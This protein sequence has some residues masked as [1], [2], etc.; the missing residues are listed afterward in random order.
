MTDRLYRADQVRQV[1]PQ[2]WVHHRELERKTL[3]QPSH[4]SSVRILKTVVA[5]P[6]SSWDWIYRTPSVTF[7]LEGRDFLI[8]PAR[9]MK[10]H[11]CVHSCSVRFWS[12]TK[13]CIKYLIRGTYGPECLAHE[14]LGGMHYL[15]VRGACFASVN[16]KW[17]S[18]WQSLEDPDG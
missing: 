7:F 4:V 14:I 6:K 3:I 16:R 8:V 18:Q 9:D 5:F 15:R 2:S 11:H 17:L 12:P 13:G 1:S 10:V